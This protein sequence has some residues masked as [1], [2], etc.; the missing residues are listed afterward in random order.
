M[1]TS[2]P[3]STPRTVGGQLDR[4]QHELVQQRLHREPPRCSSRPSARGRQN[5]SHSGNP[6][7]PMTPDNR[8]VSRMGKIRGDW[9]LDEH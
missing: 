9:V 2:E 8:S 3:I 6:M 1:P 5:R 4:Y 7:T